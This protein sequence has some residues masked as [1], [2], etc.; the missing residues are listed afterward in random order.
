MKP[1]SAESPRDCHIRRFIEGLEQTEAHAKVYQMHGVEAATPG[2]DAGNL[3][4][5][6]DLAGDC[7]FGLSVLMLSPLFIRQEP[8][9]TCSTTS[10]P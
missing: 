5:G 3:L 4:I 1:H 7:I 8:Q 2:E 10:Q 6:A 9:A